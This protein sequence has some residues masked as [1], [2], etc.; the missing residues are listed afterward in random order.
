MAGG[1]IEHQ[2]RVLTANVKRFGAIE[3]LTVAAFLP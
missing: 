3:G 2:Q 1:A